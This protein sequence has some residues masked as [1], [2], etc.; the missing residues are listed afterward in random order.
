MSVQ[1]MHMSPAKESESALRSFAAP[2]RPNLTSISD[3]SDRGVEEGYSAAVRV[4]VDAVKA[5]SL[6][7]VVV[8]LD[9]VGGRASTISSRI[10]RRRGWEPE[11][12][13]K[14][15]PR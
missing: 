5:S 9:A 1:V 11:E 12:L 8:H 13:T 10:G 14:R 3:G 15:H 7:A 4:Q 2:N 6:G